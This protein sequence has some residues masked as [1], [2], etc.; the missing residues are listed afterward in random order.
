MK[1]V[2]LLI[3][4]GL[5]IGLVSCGKKG[6]MDPMSLAYDSKPLKM[7]EIALTSNEKRSLVLRATATWC[8]P[9]GSWGKIM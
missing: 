8:P 7:M 5:I 1:N 3:S 9:C 2:K 4:V 6:C